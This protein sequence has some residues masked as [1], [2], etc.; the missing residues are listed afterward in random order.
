MQRVRGLLQVQGLEHAVSFSGGPQQ[1]SHWDWD[2]TRSARL[3]REC[4]LLVCSW[5]RAPPDGP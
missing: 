1:S 2:W 3:L 5:N 4:L